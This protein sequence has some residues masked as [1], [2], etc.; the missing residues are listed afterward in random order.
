[1]PFM[2]LTL[3]HIPPQIS[4]FIRRAS[5]LPP[6]PSSP[7]CVGLAVCALFLLVGLALAGD[8]GIHIDEPFQRRTAQANLNYILGQT[9][10]VLTRIYH[11]RV[12]GVTFELPLL[13]AER[14][15]GLT[16]EHD[17][18]HLR[19]LLTHLFF[20]VGAFFCY[21]LAY[22]LFDNR[23]IAL[24]ALLIFLL[25][26]R[27]YGHSFGN[28]KDPPLYQYVH[29][30]PLSAGTGFPQ[31]YRRGFYPVGRSRRAADQPADYGSNAFC[32]H[33]GNAGTG[34]VLCRELAAAAGAYCGRPGCS[35]WP[36]G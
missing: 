27:I 14:A 17:I 2:L 1:M 5:I 18:N 22:R 28:S 24:F 12:Y 19:S 3:R 11:D 30:C 4:R 32:R 36:P 15:L 9:D 35:P 6:P 23:W 34:F 25:H 21:R 20:I 8:Y 31:R 33:P 16:D 13:L 29:Y 7:T 26:P 10:R